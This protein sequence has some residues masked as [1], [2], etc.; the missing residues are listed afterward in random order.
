MAQLSLEEIGIPPHRDIA[1]HLTRRE[2]DEE[3]SEDT[4]AS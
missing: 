1:V 2:P 3:I 4:P